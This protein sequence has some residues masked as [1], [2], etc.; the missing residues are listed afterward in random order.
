VA[1]RRTHVGFIAQGQVAVG[2]IA[3]GGVAIGIVAVGAVSVGVV[4]IGGIAL[5]GLAL[6]AV[7]L[8]F[9]AVG[10][11]SLGV[12]GLLGGWGLLLALSRP[13]RPSARSRQE[14]G[15][16]DLPNRLER[17]SERVLRS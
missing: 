10:A 12:L 11:I 7:V 16:E 5:G 2:V 3:I 1:S 15:S 14:P 4:A 6:G 8:G 9:K 13:R 17:P